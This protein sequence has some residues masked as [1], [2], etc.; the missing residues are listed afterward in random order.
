MF[1]SDFLPPSQFWKIVH[2]EQDSLNSKDAETVNCQDPGFWSTLTS[3]LL[4]TQIVIGSQL[5]H[6]IGD[7]QF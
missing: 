2:L 6:G 4:H 7:A 5:F 1:D 3:L